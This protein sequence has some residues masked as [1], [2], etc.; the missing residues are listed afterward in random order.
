MLWNENFFDNLD[1]QDVDVDAEGTSI[2]VK[3]PIIQRDISR[4]GAFLLIDAEK[5]QAAIP[6]S[7]VPASEY[8]GMPFPEGK[9][10]LQVY[11]SEKRDV[12]G[13][14]EL[15]YTEVV[16]SIPVLYQDQPVIYV[17]SMPATSNEAVLGV[18]ALWN[19]PG[20][21][22]DVTKEETDDDV[23]DVVSADGQTILTIK[24]PKGS[25][26]IS[27]MQTDLVAPGKEGGLALVHAGMQVEMS[28][29][30]GSDAL[31]EFG[32]H[33]FVDQL[34]DLDI[35]PVVMCFHAPRIQ[36][37]VDAAKEIS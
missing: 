31:L 3:V 2:T 27:E 34:K 15:P 16:F 26:N 25:T 9:A 7:L 29:G 17:I 6:A 35:G 21:L 20:F 28:M 33:P 30:Q 23:T 36:I 10:M 4:L 18:K 37:W 13:M 8:A 11:V 24:V 22:V 14:K 32:D 12:D 5:A 19:F 1:V